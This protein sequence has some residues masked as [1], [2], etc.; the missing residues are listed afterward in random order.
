MLIS[1]PNLSKAES[2][3]RVNQKNMA[4]LK[5]DPTVIK[6]MQRLENNP[7]IQ[8]GIKNIRKNPVMVNQLKRLLKNP[9]FIRTL[10]K[11]PSKK[12]AREANRYLTKVFPGGVSVKTFAL[13]IIFGLI[14]S[15]GT[16]FGIYYLSTLIW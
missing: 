2:L 10:Q 12:T 7:A 14:V 5:R 1:T 6:Q 16:N 3:L 8:A 11:P 13:V 4:A 9:G 15:F